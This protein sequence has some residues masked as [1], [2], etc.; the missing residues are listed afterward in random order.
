MSSSRIGNETELKALVEIVVCGIRSSIEL[1]CVRLSSS[2]NS[3]IRI[4][5]TLYRSVQIQSSSKFCSYQST[6]EQDLVI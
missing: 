5:C 4:Q 2:T 3:M 6:A 1:Q